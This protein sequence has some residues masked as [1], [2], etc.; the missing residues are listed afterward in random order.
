MLLL[1]LLLLPLK[2]TAKLLIYSIGTI[3]ILFF[4]VMTITNGIFSGLIKVIGSFILLMCGFASVSYTHLSGYAK[5]GGK[6]IVGGEAWVSGEAQ[7]SDDGLINSNNDYLYEKGLGS[8]NRPCL[9][10]T[11]I[12]WKI[13][14]G[15]AVQE[16]Q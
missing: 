3:I 5:V 11:S 14:N 1:K 12:Y 16:A 8:H 13:G 9:L 10:Y 6:A 15:F 2:L 4:F 7:V